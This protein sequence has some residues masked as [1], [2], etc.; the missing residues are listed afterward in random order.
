LPIGDAVLAVRPLRSQPARQPDS[1]SLSEQA[2]RSIRE[3]I[4]RGEIPLGAP[5]S[6]RQLAI[7]FGMSLLP[8]TEALQS[9]ERDGLVESRPRVGTRVCLPTAEDVSDR[10]QVREALESQAA[11]LY[12]ERVA[13]QEMSARD[14]QRMEK[15]AE[16]LDALFSRASAKAGNR[17][18]LHSVHSYHLEFHTRIAELARN[19]VLR[20]MIEKNHVLIFNWL[21]DV[22]SRRPPLPPH[23][24]RDLIAALNTGRV[25]AACQA[26]RKHVR[27]GLEAV[28]ENLASR[29]GAVRFERVKQLRSA[30]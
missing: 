17:D 6:R 10:Y 3:K 1:I 12:A 11:R 14:M 9:L 5:L 25:E 8:V 24:H 16:R 18:V 2:Y 23:F 15:M 19:R 30:L 20:E 28:V 29:A 13:R 21:Y 22:A 27:F 7:E 26:M 4:L